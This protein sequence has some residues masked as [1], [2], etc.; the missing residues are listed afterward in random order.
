MKYTGSID[1]S[2]FLRFLQK[3]QMHMIPCTIEEIN[4]LK[5][6]TE[7]SPLPI[8][9]IE[10]MKKAG[11]GIRMFAGSDFKC[12]E[13]ANLKASAL[14]LLAENDFT[15]TLLDNHFV[16]FMHQ[17]YQFYFFDLDDGDNSPVYYYGEEENA[18]RF[19]RKS[20]TFTEFLVD[21]YNEIESFS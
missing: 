12:K 15:E 5:K 4:Q 9:Y 13:V 10:F 19:T 20:N 2:A 17:G 18:N 21:Y 16:F 14:E 8:S 3:E 1:I 7:N 6:L 11:N